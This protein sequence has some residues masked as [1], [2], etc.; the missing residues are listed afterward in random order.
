ML[1]EQVIL[2]TLP[3]TCTH[4]ALLHS[5]SDA[6]A[7]VAEGAHLVIDLSR[8]CFITSS[9]LAFLCSWGLKQ[10]GKGCRFT[11]AGDY[12]ARKYLSRMDL[13][14]HLDY[15]FDERFERHAEAGRFLPVMAVD[16]LESGQ[17]AVNQICD[18]VLHLFDNA[19]EFLP[20][21]EWAINEVIDNIFLHSETPVPGAVCAQYF[22]QRNRLDIGICD[23][24]RG[25]YASLSESQQ[26]FSHGDA[27]TKALERGVTRN[28]EI[29]QG[30][31]LAGALAI[32]SVNQG[33]FQ[34]WTGDACFELDDKGRQRFS[35]IPE[36]TGTGILI[37][38]DT[39]NPVRLEDTFIG[40]RESTY[41]FSESERVCEGEGLRVIEECL[42]TGAREP[43]RA[44]RRKI[45]ALLPDL[46]DPLVLNFEGVR[47]ASSSFLDELLGRLY[48]EIGPEA[49]KHKI[50][51]VNADAQIMDMA[52]VVTQQR[53][54]SV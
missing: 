53:V 45:M 38:L 30:N 42:H 8:Q 23:M 44:L 18:L 13:F 48:A 12:N 47:S 52:N 41:I 25:I 51:I 34:I 26:L 36:S 6:G 2:I 4:N 17:A 40:L 33:S 5:I 35:P 9:A 43:A 49:F 3:R 20:A 10:R 50:R 7:M 22:P 24:G 15:A 28:R 29:G 14:R 46:D 11:F 1:S 19:R 31:G 27:I 37:R 54:E 16:S 32:S 21:M 39:R